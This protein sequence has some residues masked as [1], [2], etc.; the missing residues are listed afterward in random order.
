MVEP[1][2]LVAAITD[3]STSTEVD[4]NFELTSLEAAIRAF[5][6]FTALFWMLSV[7]FAVIAVSEV[8]ASRALLRIEVAVSAPTADSARS[9]SA[10]SDL[11]RLVA[12][13]DAATRVL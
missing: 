13:E 1:K 11:T 4:L 3:R 9:T 6:A 7:V 10:D 12:S 2:L 8:C 5:C